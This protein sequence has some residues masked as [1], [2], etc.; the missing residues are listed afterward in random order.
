[1]SIAQLPARPLI[2]KGVAIITAALILAGCTSS[3]GPEHD[4]EAAS[5][6]LNTLSNSVTQDGL[7]MYGGAAGVG[8]PAQSIQFEVPLDRNGLRIS[9]LCSGGDGTALVSLNE[10]GPFELPCS[11][12]GAGQEITSSLPL[13]GIRLLVK[14]EGGPENS[15]W[16]VAATSAP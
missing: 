6:A 14:V 15:T 2:R 11:E 9:G 8:G 4:S 1:M 10:Q 5:L 3:P 12:E 7:E 13:Q 16:A